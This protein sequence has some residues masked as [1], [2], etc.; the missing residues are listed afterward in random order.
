MRRII[1]SVPK[2]YAFVRFFHR[3]TVYATSFL[4]AFGLPIG[5]LRSYAPFRRGL[6][7]LLYDAG[8]GPIWSDRRAQL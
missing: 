8:T 4:S 6:F 7:S 2:S 3:S 5:L 1:D